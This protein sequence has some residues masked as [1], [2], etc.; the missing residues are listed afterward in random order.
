MVL[1]WAGARPGHRGSLPDAPLAQGPCSTPGPCLLRRAGKRCC[2]SKAR[3]ETR[4]GSR[5]PPPPHGAVPPTPP[6]A[7]HPN[8]P[9]PATQ[10]DSR[11][12]RAALL[13]EKSTIVFT[14][15]EVIISRLQLPKALPWR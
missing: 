8:P 14:A 7:L 2:S 10:A 15:W 9:S 12:S 4:R 5:P 3:T 1:C 6:L 13:C 11:R